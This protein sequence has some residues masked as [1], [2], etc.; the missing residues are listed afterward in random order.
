MKIKSCRICN[1]SKLTYLFS[2]GN[3]CFTGKFPTNEQKIKKKPIE[4]ILCNN[5]GLVQ[6]AHNF[7][8][9]YL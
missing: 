5:C 3:L 8:L 2:L 7:D 6:L 4:V 9:K 1:S